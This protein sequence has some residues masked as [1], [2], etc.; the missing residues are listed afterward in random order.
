MF[1]KNDITVTPQQSFPFCYYS[2]VI[3]LPSVQ[4]TKNHLKILF[5]SDIKKKNWIINN[6]EKR[7]VPRKKIRSIF[8]L[9]TK[10]ILQVY[11]TY[12]LYIFE[13]KVQVILHRRVGNMI[14]YNSD[15]H[16]SFGLQSF[17][18]TRFPNVIL[19]RTL[20]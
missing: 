7:V 17:P 2:T 10:W 9:Q 19:T 12:S 3:V 4:F 14:I 1:V 20:C 18:R 8:P 16:I 5:L 11:F 6:N 15:S 13:W